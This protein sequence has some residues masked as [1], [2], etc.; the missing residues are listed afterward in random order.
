MVLV[1]SLSSK[2]EAETLIGQSFVLNAQE[3]DVVSV[4][5]MSLHDRGLTKTVAPTTVVPPSSDVPRSVS[6]Q[7]LSYRHDPN[8]GGLPDTSNRSFRPILRSSLVLEEGDDILDDEAELS[9][10]AASAALEI[11]GAAAT[12]KDAPLRRST[13]VSKES[14]L[15]VSWFAERGLMSRRSFEKYK[16]EMRESRRRMTM[17]DE[18]G[19]MK[20]MSKSSR[21][22]EEFDFT[23]PDLVPELP[24]R[25]PSLSNLG[26]E[27]LQGDRHHLQSP[28]KHVTDEKTRPVHKSRSLDNGLDYLVRSLVAALSHE[29]V[30]DGESETK[31][32]SRLKTELSTSLKSTAARGALNKDDVE[33]LT[34]MLTKVMDPTRKE[35]QDD[36]SVESND[37]LK[38]SDSAET[39]RMRSSV[40]MNDEDNKLDD[41]PEFV[42]KFRYAPRRLGS[43][44]VGVGL[45]SADDLDASDITDFTHSRAHSG[46]TNLAVVESNIID[47]NK[48][49]AI[50]PTKTLLPRPS[51]MDHNESLTSLNP[52]PSD[53]ANSSLTD[54]ACET[55]FLEDLKQKSAA[56]GSDS[57]SLVR[58][59]TPPTTQNVNYQNGSSQSFKT[60]PKSP[61]RRRT[62]FKETRVISTRRSSA[63][64]ELDY[65]SLDGPMQKEGCG[66]VLAEGM[67][68]LSMAML[69]SVYGKLREMSVLGHASVKFVDIDVNSHQRI[70]RLKEMKRRGLLEQLAKEEKKGEYSVLTLFTLVC[71]LFTQ[72]FCI[73]LQAS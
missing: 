19:N 28:S 18:G 60:S 20:Y 57:P 64:L 56:T 71:L 51:F 40:K 39:L 65:I 48:L 69:C 27:L 63:S 70:S 3:E 16:Q 42:T 30:R 41:K 15:D 55:L 25:E 10:L 66:D 33:L 58:P 44:E 35:I 1:A 29:G 7:A 38:A 52:L 32:V 17:H 2:D 5:D 61:L 72:E 6:T 68:Y 21:K 62:S 45:D 36:D 34:K 12:R 26:R 43:K 50:S 53:R 11:S 31:Q 14:S 23:S 24:R 67:E 9:R 8:K 54:L 4:L 73:K 47:A 46:G 59:T 37:I 22:N 49:N 13:L